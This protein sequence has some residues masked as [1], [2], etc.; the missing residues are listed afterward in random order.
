MIEIKEGR[1]FLGMFFGNIPK[2]FSFNKMGGDVMGMVWRNDN[3]PFDWIFDFRFRW[4]N[5]FDKATSFDNVEESGDTKTWYQ[6]KFTNKTESEVI[7]ELYKFISFISNEKDN[8]FYVENPIFW[9]V[10]GGPDVFFKKMEEDAPPFMHAKRLTAEECL[11]R[12]LITKE[13]YEEVKKSEKTDEKNDDHKRK[14]NIYSR[15]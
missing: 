11:E 8:F 9:E 6:S 7:K 2:E 4:N 12:K 1:Y 15:R 14:T 5:K 3:E 10:R 13:K